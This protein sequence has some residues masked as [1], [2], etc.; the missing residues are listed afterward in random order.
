MRLMLVVL[1]AFLLSFQ[2]FAT[3]KVRMSDHEE[4]EIYFGLN[5]A[6]IEPH[7]AVDSLQG[8][9]QASRFITYIPIN[10]TDT[11]SGN[12][13]LTASASM[14]TGTNATGV[15]GGHLRIDILYTADNAGSIYALVSEEDSGDSKPADGEWK[16]YYPLSTVSQ[17]PDNDTKFS[18][19]ATSTDVTDSVFFDLADFCASTFS[20]CGGFGGSN[21]ESRQIYLFTTDDDLAEGDTGVDPSDYTNGVY[22][23]VAFSDD[24]PDNITPSL[25]AVDR[26]DS[27][28]T[29]NY[30][31]N[32]ISN[33]LEVRACVDESAFTGNQSIEASGCDIS[34]EIFNPESS[35][36][37][38]VSGLVNGTTYNLAVVLVNNW[39][40]GT[41]VSNVS[42]GTPL[43]I[44]TL[45]EETQ[46]FIATATLGSDGHILKRLRRF[47][48]EVLADFDWGRK[49]IDFY[50]EL[51]P[52]I[53]KLIIKS[54]VLK[55]IFRP[56]IYMAYV[57]VEY[58]WVVFGSS[59][60]LFVLLFAIS[61]RISLSR[62]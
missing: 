2:L 21:S 22:I 58:F 6:T 60:A 9:S 59:L 5:T 57:M 36:S 17:D 16:V 1:S 23:E 27:S 37:I 53:A 28:L 38:S 48:D 56:I 29:L 62:Q 39:R 52:P 61:R 26:G 49:I 51:S 35:G 18:V 14:P 30:S 40:F 8:V 25:D 34:D 46:C 41:E 50:Y 24:P 45:L 11:N 15:T 12:F 54:E 43:E 55:A 3:D 44:E 47:R 7:T 31:S 19:G 32:T 13:N 33:F 20:N 42:T 4:P 10:S